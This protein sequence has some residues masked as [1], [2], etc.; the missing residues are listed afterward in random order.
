MTILRARL[1]PAVL[2]V[3]LA[4]WL[5]T[6]VAFAAAN[7]SGSLTDPQGHAVSGASISLLRRADSSRRAALTNAEGQFSFEGIESGEYRLTAE[8][9]GFPILTKTLSVADGA[10]SANFQ[11]SAVA[12]GQGTS[13]PFADPSKL[14]LFAAGRAGGMRDGT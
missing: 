12:S 14:P 5:C 3:W 13:S 2:L 4:L 9:S 10:N 6:S 8:S 1:G 11:F 7:L